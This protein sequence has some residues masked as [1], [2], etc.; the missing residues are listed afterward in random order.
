M[1]GLDMAA[2]NM[3][4]LGK[5]ISLQEKAN[6]GKEG[7]ASDRQGYS[8]KGKKINV[9]QLPDQKSEP[10]LM[11]PKKL[12]LDQQKVKLIAIQSKGQPPKD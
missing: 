10:C 7:E 1:Q 3:G 6:E 5:R 9:V 8:L 11:K 12:N 4:S 2:R